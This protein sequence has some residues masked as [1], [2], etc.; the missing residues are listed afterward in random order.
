MYSRLKEEISFFPLWLRKQKIGV[1]TILKF[2]TASDDEE[3][4]YDDVANRFALPFAQYFSLSLFISFPLCRAILTMYLN[5]FAQS[6]FIQFVECIATYMLLRPFIE[7][8]LLSFAVVDNLRLNLKPKNVN[9]IYLYRR[10]F[11]IF[12]FI[13][14]PVRYV[15]YKW[16]TKTKRKSV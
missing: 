7:H 14:A 13:P 9:V 4:K 2:A 11:F 10:I 3:E 5:T 6:T 12:I 8:I 1:V 16:K 15:E